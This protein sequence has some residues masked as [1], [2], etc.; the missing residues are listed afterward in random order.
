MGHEDCQSENQES[1]LRDQAE[2]SVALVLVIAA[3]GRLQR[4]AVAAVSQV[5]EALAALVLDMMG[6]DAFE[7]VS[8]GRV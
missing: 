8:L 7:V 3:A 2:S 6:L 4:F 5:I 1:D